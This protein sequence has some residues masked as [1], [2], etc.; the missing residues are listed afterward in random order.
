MKTFTHEEFIA[1]VSANHTL[2]KL[3]EQKDGFYCL[4]EIVTDEITTGI[5]TD[6]T[7]YQQSWELSAARTIINRVYFIF[8]MWGHLPNQV[9][10]HKNISEHEGKEF[11]VPKETI[12]ALLKNLFKQ[13]P[14]VFS[15]ANLLKTQVVNKYLDGFN[16]NEMG[17]CEVCSYDGITKCSVFQIIRTSSFPY[18][19][20]TAPNF[21]NAQGG[22]DLA[23]ADVNPHTPRG[24][25]YFYK[26][27][28]TDTIHKFCS[29][30]C[31][32]EYSVQTNSVVHYLD[33]AT[34]GKIRGITPD[35]LKINNHL[36][37]PEE[38]KYRGQPCGNM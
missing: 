35:I 4:V 15:M 9:Q 1:L 12:L 22:F 8:K 19:Y 10:L 11:A 13:F 21:G 2:F 28:E 30:K 32:F 27:A 16:R 37:I 23:F 38:M 6:M 14:T 17:K 29:L 25:I 7:A 5:G 18:E 20:G 24:S 34:Q 31:A 33:P 26:L 3:P 36:G